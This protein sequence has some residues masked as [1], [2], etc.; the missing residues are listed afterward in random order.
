MTSVEPAVGVDAHQELAERGGL[1]GDLVLGAEDVGVVLGEGADPHQPVERARGLVPVARAELGHAVRQ[2]AVAGDALAEDL[3]VA[4][5]VHRLEREDAAVLGLGGE[6]VLAELVP[7]PRVLPQRAVDQLRRL[8][9]L[10]AGGGEAAADVALEDAVDGPALRVPEDAARGLLLD[11]EQPELAPEPAVVAALGL[12]EAV[13]MRPELLLVAP[14]GAVDALQHLVARIAAPVGAGDL[15]E[16][17]AAADMAGRRQMRAAAEVEPSALAVDRDGFA[18]GQVA[19]DLRLVG[20][21]LPLEMP[22]RVLPAPLLADERLVAGDDLAHPRLD[23]LEI[24]GGERRVAGE[25]VVEAVLDRRPDRHLGARV[26]LLHRLRHDVCRVVADQLEGLLGLPCED[27]DLAV[28]SDRAREVED[29]AA[30]LDGDRGLRE[31]RPDAGRDGR[32]GDRAVER[33]H[34]AVGKGDVH[35]T[36]IHACTPCLSRR[37]RSSRGGR[38]WEGSFC[39][40]GRPAVRRPPGT[41]NVRPGRSVGGRHSCRLRGG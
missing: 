2:V 28:A 29:L 13:E 22:D 21:A 38:V 27:P 15:E 12:L 5:A 39:R 25:V 3:D 10:V 24:V 41:G 32:A 36:V 31:P 20:L 8:D 4:G 16:L 26:E 30:D 18:L 9:L 33:L 14:R 35:R 40:P 37:P 19:D 17:E 7:V 1:A 11:V 34:A 6:H 23:P